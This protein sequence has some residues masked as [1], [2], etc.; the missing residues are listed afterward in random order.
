MTAVWTT[1]DV[2]AEDRADVVRHAVRDHVVRVDIA[3]PADPQEV[4][5]ELV[6]S[7]IGRLQI[8][9]VRAMATTVTR[10]PKLARDDDEPCL[11]VTLQGAGSS[12][13]AQHGRQAIIT[14]GQFA[15]YT[16]AD[17]YELLFDRGLDAHFFRFPI[18]AVALPE[19][20]VH[21]V[22]S[23]SL[24]SDNAVAALTGQYLQRLAESSELRSRAGAD[25]LAAPTIDLVRAALAS[26]LEDPTLARDS[27]ETTLDL[28]IFS[29]LR[30]HLGDHDLSASTI[31]AAHHISVRH[32]YTVL[33]RSGISLGDWLRTQRLEACRHEL[34][35]GA[36][37]TRTI[38]SIAH[39]WGFAD[40]TH[41]SRVFRYAYGLSP[42]EWRDT[43]LSPPLADPSSPTL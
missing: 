25:G 4:E 11:F 36:A 13:M 8:L 22:S 9:S 20:A 32:L 34:S 42:R 10:T 41:F 5:V 15:V 7:H 26:S 12:K 19:A 40:A 28:R 27:L 31:A 1:S 18:A 24:G 2:A 3:L 30:A 39:Q 33:A 43:S 35:R 6:L 17:P 16:T 38:A 29:Y 37:R 21:A 14:P 23:R